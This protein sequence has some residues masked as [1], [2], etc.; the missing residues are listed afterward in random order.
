MY[1]LWYVFIFFSGK[2]FLLIFFCRA[3]FM[4]N[5]FLKSVF[6]M[7]RFSSPSITIVGFGS[8]GCQLWSLRTCR[9]SVQTLQPFKIPTQKKKKK[10][11]GIESDRPVLFVLFCFYFLLCFP[12]LLLSIALPLLC[13]FY[14]WLLCV[15]ESF[16][17]GPGYLVFWIPLAT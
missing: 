6:T 10:N 9:T 8:L 12:L 4:E 11:P 15:V 13:A 1:C 14:V 17:S 5:K 3:G 2:V 7:E 16:F